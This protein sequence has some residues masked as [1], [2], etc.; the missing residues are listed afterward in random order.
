MYL[1]LPGCVA[2]HQNELWKHGADE[3]ASDR[4]QGS[5]SAYIDDHSSRLKTFIDDQ[6][7]LKDRYMKCFKKILQ[8]I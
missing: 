8:V 6:N 7:S 1:P 2:L 5:N 3:A 4:S